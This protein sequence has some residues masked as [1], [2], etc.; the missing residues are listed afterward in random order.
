M[1]KPK[2]QSVLD[3]LTAEIH[4]GRFQPGQR[5]PSEA[6]LVKRYGVSRITVTHAM[7]ELQRRGLIDRIAGSGS[8]MRKPAAGLFG[9]IVP[10]LAETEVFEPICRSIPAPLLWPS[11]KNTLDLCHE[12]IAHRVAGVF[13]APLEFD[14]AS[15]EVNHRA[16]Q[17][18]REANIPVVL[19][20]R[21]PNGDRADLVGIDNHQAGYLAT[22][23]LIDLGARN[24]G[25]LHRPNQAQTV[26]SRIHG[27]LDAGGRSE[28]V[29]TTSQPVHDAYVC[30]NDRIAAHLMQTLLGQGK[31]IPQDVR[32]VGIDDVNYASLLP[33]PLTTVHQP[34]AAIGQAAHRLMLDRL[35]HPQ[36]PYRQVLLDCE[37]TIRQSCG[38]KL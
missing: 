16:M 5:F 11:S 35:T 6:D 3:D 27:F 37:L 1:S 26:K 38:A 31:R 2:Y 36:Q 33:V 34:V 21:F 18:L 20:D 4:S 9:L 12:C 30:A 14:P 13:F 10:N 19:L 23:H 7:Q 25:F 22:K 32:I 15:A 28:N 17:L 8:Y 24:P 29:V